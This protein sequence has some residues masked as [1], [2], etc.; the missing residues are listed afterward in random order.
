MANNYNVDAYLFL[1][2]LCNYAPIIKYISI[3]LNKIF[4]KTNIKGLFSEQIFVSG[5]I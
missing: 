5:S 3:G 4:R 1:C 2:D